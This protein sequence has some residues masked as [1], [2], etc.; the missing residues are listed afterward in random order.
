MTITECPADLDVLFVP[1][2]LEGTVAAM[3]DAALIDFLA[4]RGAATGTARLRRRS[5]GTAVTYAKAYETLGFPRVVFGEHE[6]R[7]N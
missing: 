7:N 4:D 1:G 2:G 3:G 6:G 5:E